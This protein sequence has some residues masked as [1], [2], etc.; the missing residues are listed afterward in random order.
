MRIKTIVLQTYS[1][2]NVPYKPKHFFQFLHKG[3]Q[4]NDF[5]MV[6]GY[7]GRT[8]EYLPSLAVNKLLND[9]KSCKIEIRDAALKVQDGFMRKDQ[10]YQNSICCK[11]CWCCQ[12]LEKMDWRN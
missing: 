11:I 6:M 4:E 9:L 3:L 8:T 2:D 7:P 1:K 10:C 5:T 12:L